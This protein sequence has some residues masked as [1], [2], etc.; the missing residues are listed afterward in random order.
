MIEVAMIEWRK[1]LT[2]KYPYLMPHNSFTGKVP[3]D[4]DYSYIE[5]EYNLPKGWFMLFLQMCDDIRKP[6]E[7]SGQINE[8]RF[9][10]VKEKYGSMRCY[11]SGACEAVTNIIY[12]YE[13]LSQQVCSI[14]G[15]PAVYMTSG[16]ICPYCNDCIKES[17]ESV[18]TAEPITPQIEFTR[19]TCRNGEKTQAT[20]SVKSEWE[21]YLERIGYISD[22]R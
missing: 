8:F 22:S 20:V 6:L 18:D 21:R 5:G 15:K 14:C 7:E 17:Y 3:H 1:A 13:F 4:Y 9:L 2:E 10:Q 16:Y 12:K 11:H 19:I